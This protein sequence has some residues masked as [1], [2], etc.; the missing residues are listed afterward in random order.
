MTTLK[1]KAEIR[2]IKRLKQRFAPKGGTL[3]GQFVK[4]K[5]ARQYAKKKLKS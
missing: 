2:E 3:A 4:M 5:T 1:T